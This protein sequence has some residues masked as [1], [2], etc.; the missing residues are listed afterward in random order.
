MI[1]WN[2]LKSILLY[3]FTLFH[4]LYKGLKGFLTTIKLWYKRNFGTENSWLVIYRLGSWFSSVLKV[5]TKLKTY[6]LPLEITSLIKA[7]DYIKL[8]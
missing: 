5:E 4:T 3:V 8:N 6:H 7:L 1:L 2:S